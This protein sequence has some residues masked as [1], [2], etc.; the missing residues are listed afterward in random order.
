MAVLVCIFA[1]LGLV[2]GACAQISLDDLTG[3]GRGGAPASAGEEMTL[4]QRIARTEELIPAIRQEIASAEASLSAERAADDSVALESLER[5]VELLRQLRFLREQLVGE[6]R[7][8]IALEELIESGRSERSA[9]NAGRLAELPP[10]TFE[11]LEGLRDQRISVL[12]LLERA[13]TD[14][15]RARSELARAEDRLRQRGAERRGAREAADQSDRARQAELV[16]RRELALLEERVA[17]ATVELRRAQLD[18]AIESQALAEIRLDIVESSIAQIEPRVSFTQDDLDRQLARIENLQAQ[19]AQV[20]DGV[21]SQATRLRLRVDRWSEENRQPEPDPDLASRIQIARETLGLLGAR[22]EIIG[23]HRR[24]V[25]ALREAW[26]DRFRLARGE[27]SRD[28]LRTL[29]DEVENALAGL[30]ADEMELVQRSRLLRSR[31]AGNDAENAGLAAESVAIRSERDEARQALLAEIDSALDGIE[32]ARRVYTKLAMALER[33]DA[34]ATVWDRIVIA[35]SWITRIWTYEIVTID[36]STAITVGK[37]M[38]GLGL[39]ALAFN[40]SRWLSA[41]LGA[42]VLPRMGLN[43]HAAAAFRSIAFYVLLLTF[44]LMALRI[45]NVPLTVFA[46]LGGAVA[47]GVGF[48]SQTIASNFISG[49]ILL[50]ERPVRVGD[51]IEVGGV[52]G[53]VTNIG[54]RSTRIKTPTNIEMILPNASLLDNN[55]INWTLTDQ[56]VW[57]WIDV[58]IAYGSPTR[59]ASKLLLR[60]A[61]EHGRVLKAPPPMVRFEAFGDNSLD[62]RVVFAINLNKPGD[63]LS[64][65]S[66]IRYRIDNLFREAGITIAFPQRDIHIDPVSSMQIELKRQPR[67]VPPAKTVDSDSKPDAKV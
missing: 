3:L 40:L 25:G 12:Q 10:Y 13:Q 50:A 52:V 45:I 32:S 16:R 62:F 47:I 11:T 35:W 6:Y 23:E 41:M 38:I 59:E 33:S 14:E 31:S 19:L 27:I 29:V 1:M 65:P 9:V 48:G 2:K 53:T 46:V 60:A 42:R 28:E 58:G 67:E 8:L 7:R 51:F 66:D 54:A 39:L 34:G 30:E 22:S 49:L 5:S 63:R 55:L 57:L 44:A 15:R 20:A 26:I 18:R 61:E 17:Q 56:T 24:R 36:D 21:Q 43:I 64:I 4:A 37:L